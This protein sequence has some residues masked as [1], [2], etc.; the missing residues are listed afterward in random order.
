MSVLKTVVLLFAAV[1]WLGASV[2]ARPQTAAEAS[3]PLLDGHK[4]VNVV[5]DLL[6]FWEQAKGKKLRAQQRLWNRL[7]ENKHRDYFERAVYANAGW[8]ER[9]LLLN[10]FLKQLPGRVSSLRE[11]NKMAG[12]NIRVALMNFKARFSEYRQQRDIYLGLSFAL[13]DG[14]VRPVQNY[15]GIPDTLCLGADVLVD[16]AFEQ[17]QIAI[18]HEFFHLYHFAFLFANPS[19]AQ[20][21]TAHIPLLVEGL[22]VAGAEAVY[23]LQAETTYLHF[24]EKELRRQKDELAVNSRKFLELLK[25]GATPDQYEQWFTSRPSEEVPQRGGYLLGYEVAHRL[26][27]MY[28]FEQLV[29]MTPVQL[30]EH[31]EEQLAAMAAD[32]VLLFATTN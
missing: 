23:P 16:Y 14:S 30:R 7:V 13:F 6:I 22:A 5:D 26:L 2:V 15:D 17:M 29:R 27:A 10:H 3:D 8:E 32:R 1:L 9:R 18:A 31:V 20:I 19:L 28:T 21:R 4:I 11:F 24:S 12:A 25:E